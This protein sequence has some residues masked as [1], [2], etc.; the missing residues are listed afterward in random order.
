M[1][2]FDERNITKTEARKILGDKYSALSDKQLEQLL[3]FIYTLCTKAVKQVLERK[4]GREKVSN[5][6]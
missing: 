4:H 5:L 2:F 3:E 6:L 1:A